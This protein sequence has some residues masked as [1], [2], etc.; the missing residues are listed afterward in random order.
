MPE[1]V[2]HHQA[3]TAATVPDVWTSL[4][5]PVTWATVAGVDATSDHTHNGSDLTGFRFTASIAGVAYRGTARVSESR[6]GERMS[7][8][9]RSNELTGSIDV[10]LA[11]GELGTLLN[12]TLTMRPAGFLGPIVFPVISIAIEKG[13]ADSVD[14]LATSLG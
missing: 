7:L 11:A 5:N 10:G 6:D 8:S 4:Q 1:A 9:I 12:V 2:F 3:V 13:F 14:R